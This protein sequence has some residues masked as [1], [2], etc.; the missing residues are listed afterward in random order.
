MA[1][2]TE[3]EIDP[4]NRA[5]IV[6]LSHWRAAR[7]DRDFHRSTGNIRSNFEMIMAGHKMAWIK[8]LL[9]EIRLPPVI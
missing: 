7:R 5:Q 6:L 9:R 1:I 3:P 8:H 4:S 2:D